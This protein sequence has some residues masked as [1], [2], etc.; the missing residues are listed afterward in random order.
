MIFIRLKKID[1]PSEMK[2][3]KVKV[4]LIA[5]ATA[6]LLFFILDFIFP[7]RPHIQYATQVTDVKGTVIH[8]FLSRDD[9]WR[10]YSNVSE[11]TPLLRKTLVYKEDQYFYYHFGF[12]PFAMIRAATR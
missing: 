4:V 2:R 6:F 3:F 1:T 8:A 12:N 5:I 10:L 9:K 11:I 7:F